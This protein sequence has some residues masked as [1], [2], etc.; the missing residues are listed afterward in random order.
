MD[1]I[2]WQIISKYDTKYV[3]FGGRVARQ[4]ENIKRKCL[5]K[6]NAER[7]QIFLKSKLSK[8]ALVLTE[9]VLWQQR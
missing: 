4:R 9:D 1:V 5:R 6:K 7:E 2:T 3:I 8:V